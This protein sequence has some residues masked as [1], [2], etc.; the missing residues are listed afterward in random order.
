VTGQAG[1]RSLD[2]ADLDGLCEQVCS[3]VDEHPDGTDEQISA[4]LA[5]AWAGYHPGELAVA[6]RAALFMEKRER[7]R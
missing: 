2:D 4:D 3:W 5:P 7:R 6:L 1:Y